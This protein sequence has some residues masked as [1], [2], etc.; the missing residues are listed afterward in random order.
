MIKLC[1]EKITS[2][3][4]YNKSINDENCKIYTYVLVVSLFFIIV[5]INIKQTYK[6]SLYISSAIV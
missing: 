2:I 3:L 6:C 4:L 5:C 1:A